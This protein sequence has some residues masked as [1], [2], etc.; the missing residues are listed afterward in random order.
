MHTFDHS[1]QNYI[2][3]NSDETS[4]SIDFEAF[5]FLPARTN[6]TPQH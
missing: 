2:T 4:K 3:T 1:L 5:G 6:F